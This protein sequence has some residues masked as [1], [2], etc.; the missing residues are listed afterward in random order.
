MTHRWK[1]AVAGSVAALTVLAAPIVWQ[2]SGTPRDLIIETTPVAALQAETRA[3]RRELE[4]LRARVDGLDSR[5]SIGITALQRPALPDVPDLPSKPSEPKV[6]ELRQN[7][8]QVVLIADRRSANDGLSLATPGFLRRTF[9]LPR[10]DLND[11]CQSLTNPRLR[12]LM[13]SEPVGPIRAQMLAPALAS[14]RQVFAEVEEFEPELYKRIAS[15]GS[16]CVRLIRGSAAS[17][18]A[19]AYGL[20]V[21]LNIDGQ[22][23]NFADGRTQLGLILLADFFKRAGWIWGAG[24]SREDSMH[25]E[26]SR[27]KIEEWMRQ[28]LL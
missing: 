1:I 27:Q 3:L 18:S 17:A 15:S 20:A 9:G 7:F 26:V 23:D 28:G 6:D 5:T 8:A 2:I 11:Q 4:E 13:S 16:L 21:D 10:N 19:H 22:L 14:L 24:F 25:F 12:D